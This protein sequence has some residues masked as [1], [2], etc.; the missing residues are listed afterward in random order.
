[1]ILIGESDTSNTRKV[2]LPKGKWFDFYNRSQVYQGVSEITLTVPLDHIPVFVKSNSFYISGKMLEGNSRLWNS[3]E[4]GKNLN[5]YAFP[6]ESGD[7]VIFNYVDYSDNN[8]EKNFLMSKDEDIIKIS[9]PQLTMKAVY[10]IRADAG[11]KEVLVDNEK[12]KW[13]WDNAYKAVIFHLEK[14]K[15]Y[16]IELTLNSKE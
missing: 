15:G 7:T 16:N 14:G 9:T 2:Y 6:G 10:V 13:E 12:I 1:M 5:I 11:A 4:N 8:K 3:G